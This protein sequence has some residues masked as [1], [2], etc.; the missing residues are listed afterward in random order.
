MNG[1]TTALI[2]GG[3]Y[4]L[5]RQPQAAPTQPGQQPQPKP[6]G[7]ASGI[8]GGSA[9][10]RGG[11]PKTGG[12][13]QLA[14]GLENAFALTNLD[15]PS[16][17][18]GLFKDFNNTPQPPPDLSFFSPDSP[19]QIVSGDITGLVPDPGGAPQFGGDPSLQI[20]PTSGLVIDPNT[21]EPFGAGGGGVID[22]GVDDATDQTFET[23]PFDTEQEE[24]F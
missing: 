18:D 19:D 20:D 16:I 17:I 21:G 1:T 2:L 4:L 7:G 11:D 3:L 22:P 9:A 6:S 13:S 14:T 24:D 8:S 15:S 12:G 5:T 10:G 23:T